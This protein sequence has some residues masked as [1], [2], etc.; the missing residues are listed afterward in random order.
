M[1]DQENRELQDIRNKVAFGLDVQQF[2][3]SSIG[4]YLTRRANAVIEEADIALRSVDPEDPKAIRTL[5]NKSAA[6]S[7]FLDWMGEAVTEGE[8]AEAS[9]VAAD[10][11]QD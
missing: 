8:Q 9:F 3:G 1:N 5:Q 7:Y 11:Q 2:M 10:Q 4:Q 6:A